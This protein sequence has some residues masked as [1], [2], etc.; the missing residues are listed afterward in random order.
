VDDID[1]DPTAGIEEAVRS[2]TDYR[3]TGHTIEFYGLCP[4]CRNDRKKPDPDR[5]KNA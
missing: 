4:A 3:L 2:K 5:R 1:A